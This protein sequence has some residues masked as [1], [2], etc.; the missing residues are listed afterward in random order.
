MFDEILSMRITSC[1]DFIKTK[2]WIAV[3]LRQGPLPLRDDGTSNDSIQ[4][5]RF[6]INDDSRR[7]VAG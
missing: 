4:R 5:L 6:N 2:A 3:H 1:G 7:V